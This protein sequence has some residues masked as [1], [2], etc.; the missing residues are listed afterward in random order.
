[1]SD[2]KKKKVVLPGE[3]VGTSE[4]FLPGEGTFEED[5][6]IIASRLGVVRYNDRDMTVSMEALNPIVTVKK[7]DVVI[8]EVTGVKETMVIVDI[9]KVEGK[10]RNITGETMGTIHVSKASQ[11]YVKDLKREF[12]IGDYVRAKV[13]KAKPSIQL[14]TAYPEYGV[15]KALCTR[16]RGPMVRK[17]TMVYCPRCERTETRKISSMYG[18][19]KS[20]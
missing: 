13:I 14:T 6:K 1:M 2:S 17:G 16:C 11:A 9:K 20:V 8:G 12:R 10:D 7:G 4:E 3:V 5:G 15:I 18:K 19:I